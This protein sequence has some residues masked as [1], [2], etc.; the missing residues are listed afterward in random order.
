ML[1]FIKLGVYWGL[2][3]A[4]DRMSVRPSK[5]VTRG[6]Y[7]NV[8]SLSK[9]VLGERLTC[10][11]FGYEDGHAHLPDELRGDPEYYCFNLYNSLIEMA[12]KEDVKGTDFLEIGSGRGGGANFIAQTYAPRSMTGVELSTEAVAFCQEHYDTSNLSFKTGDA[13]ELSLEDASVDGVINVESSHC[14][15]D[16]EQF[17]AEVYRVLRPGGVFVITDCRKKE[18]IGH[19][20]NSLRSQ[21]WASVEERDITEQV[22]ASL[23][24]DSARKEQ[25]IRESGVPKFL[26]SS[27]REFA[28][29][30]GTEMYRGFADRDV[31]YVSACLRKA[32]AALH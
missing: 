12:G 7:E 1:G 23:K 3:S 20:F 31:Q 27:L 4:Q 19:F 26:H 32:P 13:M 8:S 25:M 22:V 10:M 17:V 14:Y 18:Y 5:F 15:P 30:V 21:P 2:K 24:A 16:F 29:C 6:L 28:G 11:N 9:L